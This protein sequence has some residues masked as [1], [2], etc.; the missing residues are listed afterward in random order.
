MRF[1][2]EIKLPQIKYSQSVF[3]VFLTI[4]AGFM[5]FSNL[6]NRYMWQDE[7]QTVLIAKTVTERGLPYGTDGVNFFSQS[8][9]VEYGENYLWKWHPWMQFYITAPFIK[10]LG[11]NNFTARLPFALFALATVLLCYFFVK[12][13]FNSHRKAVLASVILVLY[14]PFLIMGRMSRYYSPEMFFCLL[15]LFAYVRFLNGKKFSLLLYF[16]SLTCIFHTLYVYFFAVMAVCLAHTSFFERKKAAVLYGISL[17]AIALNA[18]FLF[19]IYSL[20]LTGAHPNLLKVSHILESARMYTAY[21]DGE[22]MP[23][24]LVALIVV[25]F[26]VRKRVKNGLGTEGK[27]YISGVSLLVGLVLSGIFFM[28]VLGHT[29][30]YRNLAP[31]VPVMAII[32]ALILA[33]AFHIKFYLGILLSFAYLIFGNLPM[34]L[35]EIT[36]NYDGPVEGMVKYLNENEKPGQSVLI[37]YGDLPLKLYTKLNVKGGLTGEPL[38]DKADWVIIRKH[39]MEEQD[40]KTAEY[41]R[42]K[43]DRNKYQMITIDYPDNYD[44]NSEFPS[45]HLFWTDKE[46]DRVVIYKRI[47]P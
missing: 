8:N 44:E 26:I 47:K 22:L 38:P 4:I 10:F 41:I 28:S 29:P 42:Q 46:E 25:Y 7:A 9:G 15:A 5:L 3:L 19:T 16:L 1:N 12:E 23:W 13:L 32:T 36:H 43:M 20:D 24:W 45:R 27:Q 37:T 35:Y 40:K 14:V 18:P 34:Y 2:P 33:P 30:F 31:L 6:G 17:A 39:I 21:I 11:F